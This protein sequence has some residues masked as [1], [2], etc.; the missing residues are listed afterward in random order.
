MS[1]LHIF[2]R[3]PLIRPVV[4][5]LQKY[6]IVPK[7]TCLALACLFWIYVGNKRVSE[8][9]LRVPV[10]MELDHDYA[11]SEIEKMFITVDV[12]GSSEDLRNITQNNI[13]AYVKIQNPT[14]GETA[15]YQ[16]RL[17]GHE[18]P[19]TVN[20]T[21]ED[22]TLFVKVERRLTRKIPVLPDITGS[23]GAE[24]FVGNIKAEPDEI[25]ISGAES[26][27][28]PVKGIMTE[29]LSLAGKRGS[30]QERIK[31]RDADLKGCDFSQ[32]LV[33]LSV[34]LFSGKDVVHLNTDV[35]IRSGSEDL[36]YQPSVRSIVI[37]VKRD[38]PDQIIPDDEFEAWVDLGEQVSPKMPVGDEEI[39]AG[40]YTVH[41]RSK[42]LRQYVAVIPDR[43]TVSA[44]RK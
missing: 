23:P 14:I 1:S 4:D 41:V 20:I 16:V 19:E 43:I 3:M 7:I 31:I 25:E 15:R 5:F 35:Q 11:V 27:I 34:P 42:T 8:T 38:K 22:K 40:I 18:I 24:F 17:V 33:D 30:F 2:S 28:R 21:P 44:R 9:H 39:P 29:P 36:R 26:I 10:Q 13:S 12:R 6:K 32:K 37:L